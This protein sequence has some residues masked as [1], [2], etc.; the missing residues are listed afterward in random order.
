VTAVISI[1]MLVLSRKASIYKNHNAGTTRKSSL[2][3]S[4]FSASGSIS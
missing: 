1:P 3:R 2:R 4:F